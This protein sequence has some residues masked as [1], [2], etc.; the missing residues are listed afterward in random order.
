M[1]NEENHSIFIDDSA[2]HHAAHF[3]WREQWGNADHYV[4]KYEHP[5][6][7][8]FQEAGIRGGHDG[9]DW[10]VFDGF[11]DALRAGEPMP[12]DAYDMATWMA[13]TALSDESLAIG[14]HPVAFPDFTKGQWLL[15]RPG[16]F[17]PVE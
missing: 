9:M 3:K 4:K 6:W 11:L 16:D 1:Y 7:I 8:R 5:I 17:A 14:G 15:R 10:L 13:V 2:E 12:V